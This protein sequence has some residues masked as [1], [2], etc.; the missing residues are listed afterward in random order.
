MKT[1]SNKQRVSNLEIL[2]MKTEWKHAGSQ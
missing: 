2:Q 1:L